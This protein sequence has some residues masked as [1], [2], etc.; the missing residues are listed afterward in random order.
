M[1]ILIW[2]NKFYCNKTP[3]FLKDVNIEKVLVPKKIYF[4]KK[5]YS[6]FTGYLYNDHKVKL[7]HIMLPKPSAYVKS[8]DE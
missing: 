6:Y 1:R 8:Y 3:V 4:D 2:K 5:N 7:L